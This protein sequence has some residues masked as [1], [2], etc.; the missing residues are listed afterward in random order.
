[1]L[2]QLKSNVG[3]S[4]CIGASFC[5]DNLEVEITGSCIQPTRFSP[6]IHEAEIRMIVIEAALFFTI[7]ATKS[8][9]L[10]ARSSTIFNLRAERI[11]HFN[12]FCCFYV[13]ARYEAAR[14]TS[15]CFP[16]DHERA[17]QQCIPTKRSSLDANDESAMASEQKNGR[18]V[19]CFIL[20][21]KILACVHDETSHHSR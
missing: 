12:C 14:Y 10:P 13:T 20:A 18:A 5:I 6:F 1:M 8:S 2:K 16:S 19:S 11:Q 21:S 15:F 7:F 9:I 17:G 3:G 4:D